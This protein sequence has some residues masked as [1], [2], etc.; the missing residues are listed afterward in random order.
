MPTWQLCANLLIPNRLCYNLSYSLS[1]ASEPY[2]NKTNYGSYTTLCLGKKQHKEDEES[3]ILDSE[4]LQG[5]IGVE[6]NIAPQRTMKKETMT[7]ITES[8][9]LISFFQTTNKKKMTS[10]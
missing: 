5:D 9:G 7:K 2:V 8:D 1:G 6:G 4:F 3:S 10:K